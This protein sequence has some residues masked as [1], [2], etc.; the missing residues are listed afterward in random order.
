MSLQAQSATLDGTSFAGLENI[1]PESMMFQPSRRGMAARR[2]PVIVRA[3]QRSYASNGNKQVLIKLPNNAIYDTRYSYLTFDVALTKT[4]GTYI[5]N[6]SGIFTLFQRV[7][8]RAG[9]T[10]I[11]DNRDYNRIYAMLWEM[12]NPI[13]VTGNIGVTVLGFGTQAQR[14]AL[15]AQSSTTYACP[16]FSGVLNTELLP[17]DNIKSGIEIEFYLDDAVNVL[18]TDGTNPSF[19]VSNVQFHIERLDMDPSYRAR[20]ASMVASQGLKLGF[21]VWNRF[22]TPLTTGSLQQITINSRNSS[23]NGMLNIFVNSSQLADPT[24]NDRFITWLPTPTGATGSIST[25][26]LIINGAIF[27]DE[28]IDC[29]NCQRWACYQMYLRWIMKWKTN[30]ILDIAP[31]INNVAFQTDR[32]VQ[33]DDLEAYPE[34]PDLVNPANTVNMNNTMLK[35]IVFT[36]TIGANYQLDT[37]VE[38][39]QEVNIARDGLI[40][41]LQ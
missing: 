18:E 15:G 19:T 6:H 5:R 2:T 41:V 7:R 10:E 36:G 22:S 13:D 20:M 3:E 8:I 4:G 37:Y 39:F 12:L 14:N 23:V 11:E 24:V 17:L 34:Y 40:T 1:V 28:P 26:Q 16:V 29:F 35:K 30:C 32:F 27:P 31:P 25:S 21:R 9:S 38:S 33:I